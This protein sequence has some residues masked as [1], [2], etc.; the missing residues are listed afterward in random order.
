MSILDMVVSPEPQYPLDQQSEAR[1]AY[2]VPS[3]N[4]EYAVT[5]RSANEQDSGEFA[6]LLRRRLL[7]SQSRV[8]RC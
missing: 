1:L 5:D 8:D 2:R 7:R 3:D 4:E 6:P